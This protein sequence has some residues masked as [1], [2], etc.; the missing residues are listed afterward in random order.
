MYEW[1]KGVC[2]DK[3]KRERRISGA[4]LVGGSRC[5]YWIT[6]S[7]TTDGTWLVI[8]TA[9]RVA[10]EDYFAVPADKVNEVAYDFEQRWLKQMV[11]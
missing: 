1:A 3:T 5:D 4:A 2:V 8:C 9:D 7:E 6:C 10:T 11:G